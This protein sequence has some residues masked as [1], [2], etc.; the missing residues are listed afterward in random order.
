[1]HCS[2]VFPDGSGVLE[3]EQLVRNTSIKTPWWCYEEPVVFPNCEC[4]T[5]LNHTL[6]PPIA[7][8]PSVT[9]SVNSTS[10][11]PFDDWTFLTHP[12]PHPIN[13]KI[14]SVQSRRGSI[15]DLVRLNASNTHHDAQH[16][17]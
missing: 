12:S 15:M 5:R 13:L 7:T 4:C 10:L 16:Q 2:D 8:T 17:L 6:L 14:Y 11:M 3:G 1:M 9:P